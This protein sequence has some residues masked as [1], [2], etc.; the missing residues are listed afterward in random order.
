MKVLVS[1]SLYCTMTPDG[2]LWTNNASYGY[3]FWTRYLDAYDEVRVLVQV[4]EESEPPEGWNQV[5]GPGVVAAPLPKFLTPVLLIKNLGKA[6]RLVREYMS[7]KPAIHM[8]LSC[9]VG[10]VVYR[11]LKPGQ[12]YGVEVV[13]D[14]YDSFA[15]GA[16]KHPARPILR[17]WMPGELKEQCAKASAVSYVTREALQRRYPPSKNAFSTYFSSINLRP[18]DFVA[19]PR[20]VT[21]K[22]GPWNLVLVGT[23][24]QLYKAPDVLLQA[25]KQCVDEGLDLQ[26]TFVG[27]GKHRQDMLELGTSLGLGDRIHFSGFLTDKRE[28]QAEIDKADLFVL[29]SRQEGLP[30]AMIEAMARAVPCIGS[31]V[32]GI[33]ELLPADEMVPPGDAPALAQKIKEI[34]NDPARMTAMSRRNLEMAEEYREE[35]LRVRRTEFYKHVRRET[36][37]WVGQ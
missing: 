20:Q 24:A 33:P 15:P 9:F 30:R 6:R 17:A 10:S 27:D 32:G 29:P 22:A 7:D 36:E 4:T 12:P 31:T 14:P 23:L 34:L 3:A 18:E 25:M 35:T 37:K 5:T 2:H 19:S 16:T 26:L 11:N 8:R 1:A 13:A 21:Q 28:I